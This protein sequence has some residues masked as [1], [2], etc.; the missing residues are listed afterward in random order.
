MAATIG[1]SGIRGSR[2]H[3]MGSSKLP[4]TKGADREPQSVR[5][6]STTQRYVARRT[7]EGLSK[8]E[9]IR[10]LKRY[11]AR[12]VYRCLAEVDGL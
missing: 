3:I 12:E 2:S 7:E 5:E 8:G 4:L 6:D 9:I 10:C 1:H 11:V